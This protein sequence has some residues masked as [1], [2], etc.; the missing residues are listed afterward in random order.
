MYFFNA[1]SN[2]YDIVRNLHAQIDSRLEDII[3]E[4]IN[5]HSTHPNDSPEIHIST[6]VNEIKESAE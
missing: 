6:I 5:N 1:V 3:D 2:R 4:H